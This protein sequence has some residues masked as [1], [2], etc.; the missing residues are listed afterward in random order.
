MKL[1]LFVLLATA[2]SAQRGMEPHKLGPDTKQPT[3]LGTVGFDQK[4]EAQI[5]LDLEFRD[6]SGRRVKLA[7]YFTGKPVILSLVY[8]ECPMLCTVTLNAVGRMLKGLP[9]DAGKEFQ[10]VTVSINPRE[11]PELARQKKDAH[12]AAYGRPGAEKGWHFLTGEEPQIRKLAATVGFRYRYD[13]A[14]DEYAHAAGIMVATPK[15]K[16]ARY[17]YGVEFPPRDVKFG[18]MEA[19]ANRIG[20][21][22]DKVLLFCYHYDATTGRYTSWVQSA[23]RLGGIAT[24]AGLGLLIGTLLLRRGPRVSHG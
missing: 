10:I 2:A 8:Y 5:P 12:I 4:L 6:E 11:T 16:L 14:R 3:I 24:V 7:E 23:V 9:F 18:L 19:S 13:A 17:Y 20:S 21:P 1:A 15:G 22:V